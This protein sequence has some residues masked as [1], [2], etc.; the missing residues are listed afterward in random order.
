M[1]KLATIRTV[2]SINPID[3]ADRLEYIT[4]KNL[5][6][7]VVVGKGELKVGDRIVYFEIDSALTLNPMFDFL[8][9]RCYKRWTNSDGKVVDECY[10]IKTAKLRGV[11]SQ[12]LAIPLTKFNDHERAGFADME[13]GRD[14]SVDLGVRHY[15]EIVES[16]ATIGGTARGSFPSSWVPKTDAER[17]Q[18]LM[19][20]FTDCKDVEFEVTEK[21]D[22]SSMTVIY[23][24]T[25]RPENPFFICSRNQEVEFNPADKWGLPLYKTNALGRLLGFYEDT[26]KE[27]AFQGELVGPAFNGNRD[28]YKESVWKIFNIWD[29]KEQRYLTPTERIQTTVMLGI[30]HVKILST[31][32]K[33]FN[34]LPTL[35]AM[36]KFVEGKTDN[37]NEREGC[38]FKSMDG[39]I[40]FK[41]I[42]NKY[43][44]KEAD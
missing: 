33:V 8:K 23:S 17:I 20:Y 26:G 13:D 42:N 37:G 5:G 10:R 2:E 14:V 28:T 36:L 9:D 30:P 29:I 25:M 35:D 12:G 38:V 32:W 24:P 27:Y 44:L 4:M 3:G 43:L 22:G 15:D 1:R 16:Y 41:C 34:E 31:N 40:M 7:K 19:S 18:N 6:W 39:K 11:V 21:A